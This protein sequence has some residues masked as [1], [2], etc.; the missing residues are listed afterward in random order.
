MKVLV[1]S[2]ATLL[3]LLSPFAAHLDPLFFDCCIPPLSTTAKFIQNSQVTIYLDSDSGFTADEIRVIKEGILDWNDESNNTGIRYTIVETPN[4]PNPGTSNTIVASYDSN[5]S[6][7]A[8]ASLTMHQDGTPNGPSIWGFMKFNSNIRDGPVNT[9]IPQLRT[10][11]RHEIGHAVGLD[12]VA[13][14]TPQ[15][16]TNCCPPGSTIMN[17]S[18]G[19]EETFITG[20]DNDQI[21]TQAAYPSVSPSPSPTPECVIELCEAG[22]AWSCSLG[23]CVGSG[24]ASPILIDVAGDGF[25]L[26]DNNGGVQFDLNND[27]LNESLSWTSTGSDDSW[28]ALD[29][30]GN[31]KIDSGLE[32]FGNFTPQSQPPAGVPKNGFL[33][34]AEFDKPLNGGNADGLITSLDA[35]YPS[36]RLWQDLN[37]NGI[38]EPN[39]LFQLE[40]LSV[41]ALELNYRTARRT[42]EHGNRFRYRARVSNEGGNR[43][44][45]WAWDVFLVESH[46][47]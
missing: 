41:K 12:N 46:D 5:H 15:I 4:P 30:N 39:E 31:G 18:W 13:S 40:E 24:C 29:R 34:L 10:T 2:I 21:D 8:V 28:L 36:L 14:C 27:G 11:A 9:I 44:G 33:A 1:L 22:C 45:R 25:A 43:V 32:L 7:T 38:S 6:N 42:D 23:Y 3:Y 17:P 16:T 20:C 47:F 35:V 26:T 37:H 19:I